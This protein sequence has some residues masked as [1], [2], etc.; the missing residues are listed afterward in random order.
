M[1][2][3]DHRLSP[4]LTPRS[5]ALVGASP[6]EGNTGLTI[7]GTLRGLGFEGRLFPVNP[8]ASEVAGER[9]YPTLED[10]PGAPDLA[11]LA[12]AAGKLEE[13]LAAVIRAGARAA[14]I[15]GACVIEGDTRPALADRLS[16]LAREAGIPVSG[17][18]SMGFC[19]YEGRV[20]INSYPFNDREPGTMAFL[21]QSGSVFG[22]IANH[23]PRAS[24]NLAVSCG[25]EL[26]T[27]VS[28]Y[29]DYA[30]DLPS[31]RVIGLFVETIR[32]PAGFMAALAK[33][34]ARDVPVVLIKAGRTEQAARMAISHSGALT[35]SDQ[36]F[37]AVCRRFGAIRVETLDELAAGMLLMNA[38]R[39]AGAG[40]LATIH[41]SGGEREM[42]VDL[43]AD[44]GV[45]FATIG[46]ATVAKLA[47]RLDY[48]L[49]PE[50]PCDA[51]G[52]GADYDGIMRD[53]FAALL[54]DSAT[55]LG[56]FFLDA[57]QGNWYSEACV[58]ACVA[59]AATTTKPV[60]LATNYSAVNHHDLA[61]RLTHQG[62]P[63]LDGTI[64]ALKAVRNAFAWRDWRA[65][66]P[67]PA[68][69]SDPEVRRRWR[70]RLGRPAPFDEAEGLAL[71]A[72]YGI[73]SPPHRVVATRAEAIAAAEAL[74]YPVVLK[75][76]APGIAHKTD[77][78][79]VRLGLATAETVGAAY[80]DVAGRLG[81]RILVAAMV[82]SGVELILGMTVDAQFGPLVLVGAGGVLVEVMRDVRALLPGADGREARGVID[83]LALRPL[84]DG[85]RGRPAA[86]VAATVKAVVGLAALARD[87]GDLIGEMDVNPLMV[88]P[89][90]VV[91]LDALV[92]PRRP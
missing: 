85:V 65:R 9:C 28:D 83:L 89:T 17:G 23:N 19:N 40:G 79:G 90:G 36:A 56:V 20:R 10:L 62:I 55:A 5:V 18:N 70:E 30:L 84:L 68:T 48:G 24:L 14:T 50:N 61:V 69:T 74:G 38:P 87:L 53:C 82:G 32:D 64:P 29:M 34:E 11:V 33:A 4:L 59:A 39:R 22:A 54:A 46:P 52:T 16:A 15:F 71:L 86:D 67:E 72:D 1:T 63:V 66:A 91:A 6:R 43:A 21:S 45:P 57:Q 27:T 8:K 37:D 80:D 26:V 47:A 75:T 25:R 73:P 49:A 41:D 31:T 3:I 13:S 77:V 92:V 81:P 2:R 12:V 88:L 78:G 44:V 35:G 7:M 51:F 42:I 58:A 60:A 76:A